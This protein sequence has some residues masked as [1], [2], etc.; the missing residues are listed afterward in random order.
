VRRILLSVLL[1]TAVALAQAPRAKTPAQPQPKAP[2]ASQ[3]IDLAKYKANAKKYA[4]SE[5]SQKI[6]SHEYTFVNI[7]PKVAAGDTACVSALVIDKRKFVM[8]DL[9]STGGPSGL[10]IPKTQPISGGLVVIKASSMDAK[11]FVVLPSGKVATL[12]GGQA[13]VDTANKT[14]YCVWN[15]AGSF[16]LTVFDYDM[17]RLAINSVNIPEPVQWYT[18]G[19]TC[20]FSAKDEKGFYSVDL[21]GKSIN[22]LEVAAAQLTKRSY[23]LDAQSLNAI[24][25]CGLEA[26]KQ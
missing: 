14:I 3:T 9:V 23:I 6:G 2:S 4:Y 1:S 11:T 8:V 10:V 19:M 22:K 20:M 17:V 5:V 7:K 18:D 21:L 13:L 24:P 26:L 25:C 16:M 15:N 12:P